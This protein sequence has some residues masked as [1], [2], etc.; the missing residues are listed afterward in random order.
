MR[1]PDYDRRVAITGLGVISPIGNDIPT[2]W[3]NLSHGVSGLAELTR[4]D[5]SRYEHKW[6]GE[7]KDFNATDWMDPKHARRTESSVHFGV[8][9]A[10]QALADSGLEITDENREDV[11][12]IFSSGAGGQGLMIDSWISL[13]DKGP[14]SVAPTFIANAL[15]DSTS[16]LI[17]IET[18]AIGHNLAVVSAC[19]TGTHSVGEAAE[20]IRRGDCTAV[21]AGSTEAPLLEV[22]HAG[23]TNMRG[24][25]SPRPG[26]PV[27][28]LCRPFDLTRNGF[29]LGE[30]AGGLLVEDLELAKKRGA[31]IYAEVVGY[32]SAADGWDMV[33]PIEHGIGSARA[34]KMA[35]D[36]WGVPADEVDVI[37]PHGTS[38][39]LGDKRESEAIWKV[40]GERSAANAKSLAISGTKSM[41]GH[42]M[43][44]AGAFEAVATVLTVKEQCIPPTV[45][46]RDFDPE[47]DLWVIDE[48]MAHPV[49]YA[50]SNNI[51]LGGHNG[52][53]IF[54]RYDGD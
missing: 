2:V 54:K 53:I 6:G 27:Q 32:G 50:L 20:V 22:G 8:A 45:N 18:G 35:L 25:G 47:C 46:Y 19:A 23:F 31:K 12:V 3:H 15:V 9:A 48:A 40:F 28:T 36:R 49:R 29:V 37:N 17:A 14:R 39:P 51:G 1:R 42:M 26:E 11:G 33:Q 21:I 44:A 5:V 41:T 38:T 7:V 16:G 34:M 43:G 24:M 13:H 52:A 30:G 10:K 4:F